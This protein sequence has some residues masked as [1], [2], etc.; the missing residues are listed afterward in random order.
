V[1]G[2]LSSG[3]ELHCGRRNSSGLE[4]GH[5]HNTAA[6]LMPDIGHGRVWLVNALLDVFNVNNLPLD[7]VP[8]LFRSWRRTETCFDPSLTWGVQ[9]K[10]LGLEG[11][12]AL[13]AS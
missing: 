7:C 6:G 10:A 9:F 2:T 1:V 8:P 12:G 5:L 11:D 4:G 3:F 13:P